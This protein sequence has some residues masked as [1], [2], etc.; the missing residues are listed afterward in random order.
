MSTF[1]F[2]SVLGIYMIYNIYIYI[3]IRFRKNKR[4]KSITSLSLTSLHSHTTIPAQG[5]KDV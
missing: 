2:C 1:S 4:K 3:Y 5:G